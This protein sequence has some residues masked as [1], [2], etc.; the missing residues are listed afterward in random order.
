MGVVAF[1]VLWVDEPPAAVNR[2]TALIS[3]ERVTT[4]LAKTRRRAM[5]PRM[6]IA[7]RTIK[8]SNVGTSYK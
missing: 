1:A 3:L 6:R 4:L 2:L 5:M 8:V 7:L